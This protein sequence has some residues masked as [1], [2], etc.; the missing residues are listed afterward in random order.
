MGDSMARK[1]KNPIRELRAFLGISQVQM[2]ERLGAFQG[3]VSAWERGERGMLADT[4]LQIWDKY[5]KPLRALGFDLEDIVRLG[6]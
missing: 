3:Q 6:R 4:A 5:K 2:A 1:T